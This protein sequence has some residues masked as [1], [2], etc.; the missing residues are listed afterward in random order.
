MEKLAL[1]RENHKRGEMMHLGIGAGMGNGHKVQRLPEDFIFSAMW[2][3]SSFTGSKKGSAM[4]GDLKRVGRFEIVLLENRRALAREM[5][6]FPN[7][8]EGKVVVRNQEFF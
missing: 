7:N 8:I 3:L 5:S 6:R 2:K 4:K 1:E